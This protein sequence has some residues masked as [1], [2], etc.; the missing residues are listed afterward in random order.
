MALVFSVFTNVKGA[1]DKE[2]LFKIT[3][4]SGGKAELR[5]AANGTTFR[6][7]LLN[8]TTPGE[9]KCKIE[10]DD[11]IFLE[12]PFKDQKYRREFK[13]GKFE[14]HEQGGKKTV[15]TEQ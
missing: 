1:D 2:I 5:G 4:P 10:G 12:G 15:W 13:N 14:L 8:G 9:W 11:F 7:V 6:F 3:E